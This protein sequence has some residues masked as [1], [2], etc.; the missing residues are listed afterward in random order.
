MLFSIVMLLFI[1]IVG[2]VTGS[3]LNVVILRTV[4]G[5]S[6]VFP[7]SKCPKCQTPLKW[8]HNI[9]VLS[10]IFLRGKCGFC[11]EKIS[12]QYPLVELL[13]GII[14]ILLF[15]K[16][17]NPFDILFGLDVVNPITYF[18]LVNYV[19]GLVFACLFI[20]IAGTDIKEMQVSD[21]HTYSL[22]G[23]G[24][25][26]SIVMAAWNL[27]V[28]KNE[29]GMPELDFK[30][31]MT[32]PVFYSIGAAIICFVFV[33]GLRRISSF[34]LKVE[35]FGEGD[36]YIAAG[37]G[38][39]FG[40]LLGNSALYSSSF[41]NI[42]YVLFA[43]FVLSA[44]LPIFFIFPI[45]MKKLYTQKNWF[46]FCGVIAFIVYAAAYMYAKN[47]GWLENNI[48]LYSSTIVLAL[49]GLLLC[50]EL[51]M[52]IKNHTS[53]GIPCPYGPALVGAAMIALLFLKIF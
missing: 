11:H 53:D 30:F 1:F 18:Q 36:A 29:V 44:I 35:T 43:I 26:Y 38:A 7:G 25:I 6:I 10:F 46:M 28:Y 24:V 52:G 21:A 34:L 51:V 31:I 22:I 32:C 5:E 40:A 37:I 2:L 3:F 49:L 45:Y 39:V 42:L 47:L 4:S 13:T 16:F 20:V 17:C 48:A 33:E 27:I 9:P 15:L 12:W 19:F 23:A 14:F 41:L 50:K 8:Y